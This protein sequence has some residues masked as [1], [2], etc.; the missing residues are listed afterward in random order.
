MVGVE[1]SVPVQEGL[2]LQVRVVCLYKREGMW[3]GVWPG[4]G[5]RQHRE[6]MFWLDGGLG[7]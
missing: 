1:L 6:V 5:G 7:H 3:K 4:Q 2:M